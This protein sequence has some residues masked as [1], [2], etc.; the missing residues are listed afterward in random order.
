MLSVWLTRY[1][2]LHSTGRSALP[3]KRLRVT[4]TLEQATKDQRRGG[5]STPRLGRFTPPSM[6]PGTHYTECWVGPR[7]G[8]DGCGKS[9][10]P[11][12]GIRYPDR[13]ALAS[14]CQ[15]SYPAPLFQVFQESRNNCILPDNRFQ[16]RP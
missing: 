7:A 6:R 4:V 16:P 11:P 3:A 10:P 9:R 12:I 5:W 2:Q 1:K 14:R 8:V 13:P 15:L